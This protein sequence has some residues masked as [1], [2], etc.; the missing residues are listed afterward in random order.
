ML[1]LEDW[2]LDLDYT[3]SST[4]HLGEATIKIK[5]VLEG[6]VARRGSELAT[7]IFMAMVNC[8]H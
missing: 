7:S 5:Q 6:T 1:I 8:E 2:N 4:L 3:I